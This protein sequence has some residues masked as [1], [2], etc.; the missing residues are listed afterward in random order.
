VDLAFIDGLHLFEYA[1]RDF[2]N[3]EQRASRC[4]LIVVDDVFP[5]HPAQASRFRHTRA[6]A[7]DVWRLLLCLG[8]QRTDLFLLPLDCS[9]IGLLVIAGLDPANRVLWQQYNP[10]V[11]Q[12]LSEVQDVPATLLGRAGSLDPAHPLLR[13]LLDGLRQLAEQGADVRT[14]RAFCDEIGGRFRYRPGS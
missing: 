5:N 14:V 4:G 7:G 9:P 13:D 1:L 12:Y 2:M 6:W 10:I 3:L 8:E 11:Q